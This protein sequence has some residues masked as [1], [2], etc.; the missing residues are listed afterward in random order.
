MLYSFAQLKVI[1]N[2]NKLFFCHTV[3]LIHR[4]IDIGEKHTVIEIES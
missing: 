3:Y 4:E 1:V 2:I